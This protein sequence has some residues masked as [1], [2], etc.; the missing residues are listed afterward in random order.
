MTRKRE[1]QVIIF[2]QGTET[3]LCPRALLAAVEDQIE[4]LDATVVHIR[5]V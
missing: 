4:T 3:S 2:T 1:L 5:Y